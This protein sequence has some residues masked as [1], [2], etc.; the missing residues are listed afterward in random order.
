MDEKRPRLKYT[1]NCRD[2]DAEENYTP[3]R[4]GREKGCCR[5]VVIQ[6]IGT[7]Q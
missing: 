7:E 6:D 4:T 5:K 1:G 2:E 3:W